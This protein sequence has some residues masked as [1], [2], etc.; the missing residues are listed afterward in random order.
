M[1]KIKLVKKRK[2]KGRQQKRK[3]VLERKKKIEDH[4]HGSLLNEK[5][6]DSWYER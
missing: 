2:R 4:C 5:K 6:T 3:I 1:K